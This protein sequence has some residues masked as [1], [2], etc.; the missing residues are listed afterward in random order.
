MLA[1]MAQLM[2]S[3][4]QAQQPAQQSM[5]QPAQLGT[6]GEAQPNIAASQ[7]QQ[8]PAAPVGVSSPADVSEKHVP[9]QEQ[10]QLVDVTGDG[11]DGGDGGD[12]DSS[13]DLLDSSEEVHFSSWNLGLTLLKLYRFIFFSVVCRMTKTK[14]RISSTT[15]RSPEMWRRQSF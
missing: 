14:K 7:V 13:C 10:E 12:S 15:R 3:M 11:G 2:A 1:F 9:E 8:Q 5:Q 6:I 4:A